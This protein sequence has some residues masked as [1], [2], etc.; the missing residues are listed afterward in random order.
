MRPN[1]LHLSTRLEFSFTFSGYFRTEMAGLEDGND[2]ALG[3]SDQRIHITREVFNLAV[4]TPESDIFA[5]CVIRLFI[6]NSHVG[7]KK[8]KCL[9]R[10]WLAC[11]DRVIREIFPLCWYKVTL[12]YL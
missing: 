5:N 6:L 12:L 9:V 2:Q 1:F 4:Y 7:L 11:R 10:P 8:Q 3:H